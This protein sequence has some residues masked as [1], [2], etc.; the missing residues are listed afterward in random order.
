M[1]AAVQE[2]VRR[3]V[4]DLSRM[5]FLDASGLRSLLTANQAARGCDTQLILSGC[6]PMVLRMLNITGTRDEFLL[7]PSCGH[8]PH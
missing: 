8:Q 6:P 4:I 7:V 2:D 3:V 1:L 5:T